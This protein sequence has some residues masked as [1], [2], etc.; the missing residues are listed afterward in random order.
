MSQTG[1]LSLHIQQDGD[2]CVSLI[3]NCDDADKFMWNTVEFCT[4]GSG[5]GKS[6]YT[7]LALIAL[8]LAMER[9]NIEQPARN[10]HGHKTPSTPPQQE[11]AESTP[12]R[13]VQVACDRCTQG[14][15][16]EGNDHMHNRCKCACH[17]AAEVKP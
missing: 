13:S 10:P 6:H 3:T 16:D 12:K 17:A 2:I 5:G 14:V 8:M 4:C 9:D 7:R 1:K 11:G 15:M